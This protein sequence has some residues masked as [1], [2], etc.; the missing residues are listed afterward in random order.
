ML[1][2][3]RNLVLAFILNFLSDEKVTYACNLSTRYNK[4]YTIHKLKK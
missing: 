3:I 2:K 4:K 1:R